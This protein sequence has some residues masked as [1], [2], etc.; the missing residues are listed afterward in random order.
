MSYAAIAQQCVN[1]SRSKS[2]LPTTMDTCAIRLMCMSREI[3]ELRDAIAAGDMH[4]MAMESADVACYAVLVMADLGNTSWQVRSKM[5]LGPPVF[6]GPDEMVAPLRKYVDKAF[7]DWRRGKQSYVIVD[8]ELLVA[9][10]VD[11]RTRCLKLPHSL[12][13]D[14][15]VKLALGAKREVCH[16]KNPHS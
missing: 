5:H 14:M 12:Q 7:E 2:F 9:Q 11:V 15:Q 6:C 13:H 16:G 4:A 8:L 1:Y 3:S 10:L